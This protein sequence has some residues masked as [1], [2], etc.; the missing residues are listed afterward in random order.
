M[1]ARLLLL[2]LELRLQR[3]LLA[4]LPLETVVIA[5]I[6]GELALIEMKNGLRRLVQQIAVVAHHDHH[7]PIVADE[8][9]EPDR[10]FEVEIV[11]RLVEQQNVG[12]G[13]QRRRQRHS[14]APAAR[15]SGAGR[16]AA[17]PR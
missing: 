3:L 9:L 17:A 1:P 10:P 14:H 12:I 16:L 7:M 4:S 15:E 2:L 13:E 5:L 8:A 6:E 11:R